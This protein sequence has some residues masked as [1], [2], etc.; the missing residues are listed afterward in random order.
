MQR[1]LGDS[2][3]MKMRRR[4][5]DVSTY[6]AGARD[7]HMLPEH[8]ADFSHQFKKID[9]FMSNRRINM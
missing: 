9:G 6:C 7:V 1:L 3:T 8:S 4:S 2:A 5:D